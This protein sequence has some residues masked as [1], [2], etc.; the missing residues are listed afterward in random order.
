MSKRSTELFLKDII[1]FFDR[2]QEYT[3][4]TNFESFK[5]NQM[6][7]DAVLRN[8]ELIG[9]AVNNLPKVIT[10]KYSGIPWSDIIGLRIITSLKYFKVDLKI[11]W[12]IVKKNIPET[13]QKVKKILEEL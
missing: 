1:T 6:L 10:D 5:K 4:D 8:L 3:K 2:I 7:I 9:E 11:I 12:D 13:K